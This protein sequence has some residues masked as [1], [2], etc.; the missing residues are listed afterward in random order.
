M[1]ASQITKTI[2]SLGYGNILD[3]AIDQAKLLILSKIEQYNNEIKFFERKYKS[4]FTAFRKKLNLQKKEDFAKEDEANEWEYAI[5]SFKMYS[6]K[7]KEL[8]K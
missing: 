8:E 3:L 7:L 2:N 5:E 6:K 1:K 4:D